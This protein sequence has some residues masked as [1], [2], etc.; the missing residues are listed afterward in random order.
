MEITGNL[1]YVA[2]V[3]EYI[4]DGNDGTINVD[5]SVNSVTIILPNINNSG[6]SN[7]SKGFIIN[8]ISSNASVNNITITANGNSVNSASSVVISNNGGSAKCSVANINEWFVI[9]EPQNDGIITSAD[10]GLNLNGSIVE[11]GGTLIRPTTIDADDTNTLIINDTSGQVFNTRDS[12]G[13]VVLYGFGGTT[14]TNTTYTFEAYSSGNAYSDSFIVLNFGSINIFDT[15]IDIFNMGSYCT[16]DNSSII[17]QLGR[18][19]EFFGSGDVTSIGNGNQLNAVYSSIIT[20]FYNT[21]NNS[22]SLSILGLYNTVDITNNLT[23][24]G[25]GN[26]ITNENDKIIIGINNN[27]LVM[28]G[29]TGNVG[30][31]TTTPTSKLQVNSLPVYTNNAD[32]LAN[33]LTQGAMYIRTSH[34]LDIVI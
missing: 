2:G 33:G 5:T 6:F 15:A 13:N 27:L 32:A 7:T 3:T 16:F 24:V 20:G 18:G 14:F 31:G 34:G 25:S 9:T 26:T 28:D 19:C 23:I 10:N 22:Q 21:L 29:T 12:S 11:L 4:I 30:I 17:Y 1:R 8:D